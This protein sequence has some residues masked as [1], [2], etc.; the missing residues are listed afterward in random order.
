MIFTFI[1]EIFPAYGFAKEIEEE[2]NPTVGGSVT[3]VYPVLE[4]EFSHC[5]LNKFD[6]NWTTFVGA[7]SPASRGIVQAR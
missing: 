2:I 7:E 1:S 6:P 3:E 4:N 5:N